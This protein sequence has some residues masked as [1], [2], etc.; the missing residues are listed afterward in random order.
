MHEPVLRVLARACGSSSPRHDGSCKLWM[1]ALRSFHDSVTIVSR[2]THV[3]YVAISL[4]SVVQ[5]AHCTETCNACCA[6]LLYD[7]TT[8]LICGLR[9]A[10]FITLATPHLGCAEVDGPSQVRGLA[11][12]PCNF[13][14]A[15]SLVD[16]GR[17]ALSPSNMTSLYALH[18]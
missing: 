6:G 15:L 8:E 1:A 7:P 5:H 2:I 13:W 16:V 11:R 14:Y 10:H 17:L 3:C 12:P 18:S 9:P 4:P